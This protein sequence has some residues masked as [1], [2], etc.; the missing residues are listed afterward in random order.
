MDLNL[1]YLIERMWDDLGL[2]KIYTKKRGAHPDL[3]D[4]VCLRKGATVEGKS[5]KF[6]P[7][8]QKVSLNHVVQDE[9]VVTIFTK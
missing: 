7:H 8:A 6:N 2:V 5:S 4:P 9:D 3:D 1:N